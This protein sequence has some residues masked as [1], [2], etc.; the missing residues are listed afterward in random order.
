MRHFG[1]TGTGQ[2]MTKP[3]RE[4]LL[5]A[6]QVHTLGW[7][8]PIVGHHGDDAGADTEFHNLCRDLGW[9][10]VLHPPSNP[11]RRGFCQADE[12]RPTKPYLDRNDDIVAE[13]QAMFA[14]PLTMAEELRSGTWATIRRARKA[15]RP[16][17]IVWRDGSVTKERVA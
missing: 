7:T 9:R 8:L 3:Q 13:S 10:V 6:M 1:F 12:S 15:G 14:A 2:G 11:R 17:I 4:A 16:L 5:R